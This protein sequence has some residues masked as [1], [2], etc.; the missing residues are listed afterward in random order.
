MTRI[1]LK[2]TKQ[3]KTKHKTKQHNTSPINGGL[4]QYNVT[5]QMIDNYYA[6]IQAKGFHSLSYFDIGNWGTSINTNY[7]GLVLIYMLYI[8]KPFL[9]RICS[10]TF[11][12]LLRP[13]F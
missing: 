2:T 11:D 9:P 13:P 6:D 4:A 5:Y 10:S 12:G 1:T 3:N 8:G 7:R